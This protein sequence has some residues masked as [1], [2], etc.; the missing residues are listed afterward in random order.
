MNSSQNKVLRRNARKGAAALSAITLAL[1]SLSIFA[2]SDFA[3][4]ATAATFTG[5]I[6]DKSGAVEKD[7]QKASDLPAGSCV[8]SKSAPEGSQA[9]FSWNTLEPSASSPDK[10]AWGL[11]VSFD[12]SQDRTFADWSF[13][14]SGN[15]GAYLDTAQIPAM[16]AGQ[17]LVD[18]VVTH[19]A[20][21]KLDIT[22]S[23]RQIN[24]NLNADLTDAKVK[25][26]AEATAA[27]PVRY[28]W[29]GKYKQDNPQR[30][31]ATQGTNSAFTAVV[32]PWPS[33][34]IE[35][36]PITVSWENF[37]KHVI[38]A[39]AET[40]VGK[41]NVP[42]V[43]G[44]G[45]DDSMSR[46]VV[47]A[48]DGN[49]Q[50]IGTTDPAAS[51][52]TKN[53]RIDET[54]GEIFF[55]WPEYRGTDLATDKN[56]NF[57]VLAKPRTVDQ[58]QAAGANNN[59]FGDSK[60]FDSSNSLTRYNKA[61]VIDS[62][63]FS[64]DDTEYHSPK[65][66]KS[67]ATIISGVDSATG[68]LATEPQKV[69]FTQ[70]P[71]LIKEL[72]KKKG[73]GGFEAKVELDEKYVYEGWSVEMDEN[74]N[75]TVTA[76]ESPKPG[77]FAR[78]VVTVEYSNGSTDKLELLVVVDPNNTQVTDLVR[79]GLSKG[80]L[81]EDITAQVGTKSIMKGHKPVH[82]AKFEIDEST[83]PDGWTVTVDG[84]G[85]VT[86]KADDTVAP[87]SIITPKVKATYPDGTT[88]EIETQFQAIVDIKI[89]TYDTVANKPNAKVSLTPKLPERG[90]SGNTSDEAP[91]RYTFKDGKTEYTH[92]D[93]S[94]TWTVKIDENTGKITTTIPKT[95]PEGYILD[96]PVLAYYD[97]AD[98]PQEV[99][100]TVVVLKSDIAPTYDVKVTGPNQAVNHQVQDAPK[101]SKFSFGKNDDGS[102]ITEQEV[103]G[104]KYKVDPNTGEVTSTPPAD[105]KPGD[106]NTTTVTVEAPDGSSP[107]VPVTTVVKL[108]N[109]WEAEPSYP[110]ETVYPGE[111]ATLPVALDKPENVNVAKDNP[112]KLGKVPA[113]WTVSIDDKGQITATAPADAK[114]GDQVKIPVTVTYEDGSTDTAYGVVNVVDV[115]TREV[116]FKVEYKYDDS[117]P[118]GKYKVE[119]KGEP[120]E[121][122]QNKDGTWKQ[123]KAPVNEV[124]V[125][126]TKPAESAKDVTW[127]V[128]I[129]YQT[130]VR[131]NPDLK[132]GE[133][134][135]V[136]EG[137]NGEKTYTAKFTAKG[138]KAE[139]AEE[140][141]TKEPVKRI[142][143]YGPGLAPSELVTK[144]EKPIPF[145]TE[146]EFDPNLPAGEKVVDQKG[147]LGTEVETSTQK[148]VD[149]KPSGDP[150]VTT[151]RT[152][153]PTTEKIRV[154]TKTTGEVK[155]SVESE[156]PFGVKVEFDPNM[157]AGTSKTVTEGK[158]GKKTITV[159]QKVTNSQ[160]DGEAIVEE[161]V[162]EK[163][164]DQVIKV[165]TKPSEASSTVTWT[166]QVPFEVE[167]RPNPELKPGEI[168]VVQKGV[169]GE[170]TYTADFTAKGSEGSVKAEEKQTKDPVKEIIE[171]GPA[172]EDTTVVTKVEKPV[173]FETEIVFDD[174]LE[175]GQQKV[176]QQGETGTEVVTSTQKIVD[177]KPSGDPKVT[178]E[179]TK[180][181][182][183]QIIRVGTKTTGKNTE[184]I[185]TEVP[186]DVKVVY[187]PS[188]KP[189]ESKVTQEGKPGKKKVTIDRDIVNSKPGDP[190][191]T[192][193]IIEKPVEKI[194]T[195][196]TKPAEATNK[197]TWVAPLPYDTIVRE[198]PELKPGEMKVV[199][200]G[201]YGEKEFTA[202]FTAK[203]STS[204]VNT[205]EKV[206]KQPV[207]QIIEYGPK[208][209]DSEVVTKL[210]KP[211]PFETKIVFDP[212]LKAGEQVVDQQGELGTELVTSTQK[213][214]DGKP[215][216][217]PT[218]TTERTKE[219]VNAIIRVGTKPEG[220][221][222]VSTDVEWIEKTP[223]ETEI[224]VNPD[225]Q[226]GETKV[227]Q[228]GTLGEIKHT[229]KVTVNNGE[230][231]KEESSEEISKPSPRIIEVGP[232]KGVETELTDKHTEE[233]PYDTLIEYDPNLEAGKVIEDQAGKTGS[234]EITK[235]WKLV[236]GQPV[237]EPETSEEITQPKQDRKI[238]VGTK[239]DC[240][241]TE[242]PKPEDPKPEDPK[243][244]DPKPEDPKPEDPKP[245]DPKPEDP[246]PED[247]KP[248]D[249]KPEDPKDPKPEDPKDPNTPGGS[250]GS[251]TPKPN[252]P[253]IIGSLGIGGAIVGS[254]S[255]GSTP[256]PDPKQPGKPG[257]PNKPDA[258]QPGKPGKPGSADKPGTPGKSSTPS[259]PGS[260]GSTSTGS[261][262]NTG[263]S[264]STGSS[265][266][267]K[268]VNSPRMSTLASTG[269]NVLG[270]FA[271][272]LAL[273]IG[274]I[275][276]LRRRR[277]E[278]E[279]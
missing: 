115:P 171:Y 145:E 91:K 209:D 240:K 46:M 255:H 100:G 212:T 236:D 153:E 183:K 166:T 110:V 59:E 52:G 258:K 210:E 68:P 191:I 60:A 244:E 193:E 256:K 229:T 208:A 106:Q 204:T 232:A 80:K 123:T 167:T 156:V 11:S 27:N 18:K 147:E 50:F 37:E 231:S 67:D 133:T 186:Y 28:A 87:G 128:P 251:V 226:P 159:T 81:N 76:P 33:E 93:D 137:E 189:G 78:P 57:S 188:L 113:G 152:K 219:P 173:P 276:L 138:D 155:K 70:T 211:V 163:P 269:A 266:S 96:I 261:S 101:G 66:D 142:V 122:K 132:P 233:I 114:P 179:R 141:T 169:P 225:L 58:L 19:K 144:T 136:Q 259:K 29:Q 111:T 271:V 241:P 172:A 79:P 98:K 21:E 181:P 154:G 218:V 224:R 86:A 174:S 25:Q 238:R 35:C 149:G 202:D 227:V 90:L 207:Q 48:Y 243:P 65:Y 51:G 168:K 234:K 257:T 253:G 178:T 125:V 45:T 203:D 116:P 196:G 126:G 89:P 54:T 279:A 170:K 120:G 217:E 83:V 200:Q 252:L 242:D 6:R 249:P 162:T 201:E 265:S 92:T 7:K 39:G 5:G 71:D 273:I 23:G 135:V 103:D 151:E 197:A 199:Q 84:T 221:K 246:K 275:P 268:Q 180:E 82:P 36:N 119:T 12:N 248:E 245:E 1:G 161:K 131:E 69:T 274:A 108:T 95:A 22:A 175:E 41:I 118:A 260:K 127:T 53:L 206:T 278:G 8:V 74:Y 24:L 109:K 49:G 55:T 247:P 94:G 160:P 9:G 177:G 230:V 43:T 195:V 176:D 214:V 215:S 2:P 61:N 192:E 30:P 228:E 139:V 143:E 26:F 31:R 34:N 157:P 205:T 16:N 140:E 124:V 88:D 56:V 38:V 63:A 102:P 134:R 97:N 42:A 223:F 264:A 146:V 20:D 198:N 250:S 184:S 13:T 254:G 272:G 165:G 237:G 187:D 216:G 277:E 220:T 14:N 182:T 40:K 17:T 15:M 99:K 64:L 194:V 62:K 104:W 164:V 185:E 235:T 239:C 107:K 85:K 263:S 75:V 130:E 44:E 270:V 150:T 148:L 262:T 112:Y 77:T 32:N 4:E 213:I 117:I 129:P 158:P 47:E 10:K 105:A 190:K 222:P 72:A 3:P 267:Q 73:D 121:E